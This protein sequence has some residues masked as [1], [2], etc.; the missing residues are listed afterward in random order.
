MAI[1]AAGIIFSSLNDNTLSRL[2][3]DRTV[4]AIPFACRYRLVDFCL[5]NLVNANISNVNI[6]ANYNYRSLK[7]HIGSGKDWDLARRSGGIQIISPYQTAKSS[8]AKMFST[9]MEAL[10]AI[11]DYI[12][13]MKEDYVVLMDSD[14]VLNIDLKD[15]ITSHESSGANMTVVGYTINSEYS[16]KH[17]RMMLY[18]ENGKIM[19]ITMGSKYSST[20]PTL[21][22]NIFVMSVVYLRK[23]IEE[24][25]AYKESS[26][27]SLIFK[28]YKYSDY[29]VYSY[30]G[31]VASVS[32]FLDYYKCSMELAINTEARLSL[33][34]KKENL[35]FT[36]VHNSAPVS[37]RA[38][39][40]IKNSLIADDCIIDG[41]VENSVIFRNVRIEK[42]ATVRNSV[43]FSGTVVSANASLNAIVTDKDV[44]IT[45]GVNLSG[46]D[47]MPFYIQKGRK[48]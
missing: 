11:K 20:H 23:L 47:N 15:V 32:S 43:L 6:V 22:L 14:N 41:T 44:Y 34:H 39:A 38:N 19:D 33:L 18:S 26:L 24:A 16:S 2:T 9:R 35:I 31:Y 30:E 36:R 40:K 37:Y 25:S 17:D 5:S 4:S 28:N 1:S 8:T 10:I 3:S 7:E 42:G 21:C 48:V 29:R 13:E 12:N 45:E 46:N 27:T